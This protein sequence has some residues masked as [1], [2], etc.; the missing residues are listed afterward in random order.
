MLENEDIL[1]LAALSLAWMVPRKNGWN[2][3]GEG[4]YKVDLQASP[5]QESP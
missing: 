1:V 4:H 2:Q 3:D 5:A